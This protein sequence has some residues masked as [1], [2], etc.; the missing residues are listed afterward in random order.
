MAKA[1]RRART[2]MKLSLDDVAEAT[3]IPRRALAAFEGEG[4][5]D[6]LPDPPYDRYFLREYAR[7]LQIPGEPLLAAWAARPGRRDTGIELLP[8]PRPRRWPVW[9]M[10]VLSAGVVMAL[11][12]MRLSSPEGPAVLAGPGAPPA[13]EAP[14]AVETTS[15]PPRSPA[16]APNGITAALRLAAPCWIHAVAD[17]EVVMSATVGAGEVVRLHARRTLV[18]RLGNATE[19][20]LTVNGQRISTTRQGDVLDLSFYWKDGTLR[21]E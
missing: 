8:V 5:E 15:A 9:T 18:L 17:G 13:T 11:A 1:L 3:R 14:R 6:G 10:A 7:Y 12:L 19:V 20:A 16:P 21:R 2:K 4:P